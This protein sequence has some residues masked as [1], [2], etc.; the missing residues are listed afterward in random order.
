M[1]LSLLAM[2]AVAATHTIAI[3]HNGKRID[4]IYQARTDVS[5]KT[6]GSS[7]PTRMDAQ[8]CRWN[9]AIVVERKMAHAPS[10]ARTLPSDHKISGNQP[11]ACPGNKNVIAREI[12]LREDEVKAHLMAVAEQDRNLLVAELDATRAL[13]AN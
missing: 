13:A 1:S 2:A 11:G 12:A 7:A 6:V 3:D 9:A 10:L 8:R 5:M 4:A